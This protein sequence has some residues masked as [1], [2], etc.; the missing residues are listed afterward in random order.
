[1]SYTDEGKEGGCAPNYAPLAATDAANGMIVVG[2]LEPIGNDAAIDSKT[3]GI[4]EKI[5]GNRRVGP[6]CRSVNQQ[7]AS[8]QGS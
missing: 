4:L 8:R 2:Q 1:M 3:E 6:C 5:T 7:T